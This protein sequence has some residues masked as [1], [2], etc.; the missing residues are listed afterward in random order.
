MFPSMLPSMLPTETKIGTERRMFWERCVLAWLGSV[1]GRSAD[2]IS[3]ADSALSE[4]DKRFK[5]QPGGRIG[6]P[7]GE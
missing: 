6:K 7:E 3:V 1:G 2:A 5:L 4:W